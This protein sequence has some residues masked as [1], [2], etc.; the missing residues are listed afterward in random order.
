MMAY[1]HKIVANIAEEQ[2][3][4]KSDVIHNALDEFTSILSENIDSIGPVEGGTV[5]VAVRQRDEA[6]SRALARLGITEDTKVS[7]SRIISDA[8]AY[9]AGQQL[10]GKVKQRKKA[11]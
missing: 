2:G 7:R 3:V 10:L 11:A 4:T 9:Y 5:S 8:V 6:I 1:L